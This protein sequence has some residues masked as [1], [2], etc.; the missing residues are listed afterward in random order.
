M[1]EIITNHHPRYIVDGVHLSDDE[2]KDFSYI[3]WDGVDAGT[4][5]ASFFQYK[6]SLYDLNEFTVTSIPGWDG[7]LPDS[8]WTGVLIKLTSDGESVVVGRAISKG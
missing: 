6:G 4:D 1:L 7:V 2:R 5:S 8:A 3:N